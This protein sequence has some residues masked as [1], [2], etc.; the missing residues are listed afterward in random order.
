[1]EP[2]QVDPVSPWQNGYVESFHG[3][4]RDECLNEELFWSRG[5]AQ[6]VMD[7]YRQVYNNLRPHSALGYKAP[8]QYAVDSYACRN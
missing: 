2:I 7:W 5:E 1:M 3:K 4:L 8:A 6:V